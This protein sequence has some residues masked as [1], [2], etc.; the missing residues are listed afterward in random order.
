MIRPL[1]STG[2]IVVAAAVFAAVAFLGHDDAGPIVPADR[3]EVVFWH[4]WGG[5]DREVVDEIVRRFNVRQDEFFV[6]AI[7]MP[8]NNLDL[9]LF[10]AITGGD[11]PDVIN[12]DDPIVADWAA[13]GAIT[14]LD[15]VATAAEIELLSTWLFP[16]AARLGSYDNRL[17][18]LC[19]GL[20]IRAL[21]YNQSM[22]EEFGLQPPTSVEQLDR[23]AATIAPPS[24]ELR[25]RYGYL[26]DPRRLWA[27]GVVF[28]GDFFDPAS[29]RI[30]A[31]DPAIIAA[32][33]WMRGYSDRYGKA[34]IAAFRTG[35][36]SLPGKS[37]PL[38]AGRYAVVMDGQWRVRDIAASQAEQRATGGPVTQYGVCPLPAPPGGR[39]R[40]G[41]VNGN[42]FLI[43]NGARN[44]RGAWQFMKFWSGFDGHEPAAAETC[45]AGGWIPP[46]QRVVDEP[47]FRQ[48]L[49]Q[50]PLFA[51][52]VELAGS[53]NQ[54][55][56]PAIPGAPFF[57][58]EVNNT[59]A[60]CL[61]R[62]DESPA[63]LLRDCT[64]RVQSHVER[65]RAQARR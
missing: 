48:Y 38:L 49:D 65:A 24:D 58:Q 20:D 7:A 26:P 27:W 51:R 10:L 17:Y 47:A 36:Q 22:L 6:R 60:R 19:N 57:Y 39:Q 5:Q 8:G 21:Y 15:Q 3:Q 37:F 62:S 4:F 25:D 32:L 41:W 14:P 42:F 56:T 54:V 9:K 40:A 13:R 34:N 59:A 2:V 43:P 28:G 46:S 31:D 35:D 23:I 44:P 63:S 53:P 64:E 12:H 50:E 16:A 11:P 52:F 61:F 45:I 29:E 18:A 33:Q 30:T 55:P 1:K